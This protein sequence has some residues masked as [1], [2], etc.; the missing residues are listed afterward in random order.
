MIPQVKLITKLPNQALC[1]FLN[2]VAKI[3]TDMYLL[4]VTSLLCLLLMA[5]Y[6]NIKVI[7]ICEYALENSSD[8]AG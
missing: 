6:V 2:S 3:G 4:P 7:E 1:I 8:V 5:E